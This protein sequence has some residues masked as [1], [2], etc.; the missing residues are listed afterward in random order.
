MHYVGTIWTTSSVNE[1]GLCLGMTGLTGTSIREDGIPTL[2]LIHAVAE[3]CRTVVEAEEMCAGFELRSRGFSLLIGDATGDIGIIEKHVA[4]QAVRRPDAPGDAVWQTNHCCAASL[5]G[6][7]DPGSTLMENSRARERFMAQA[8]PTVDRSFEGL[9]RLYR[10]HG[11][12]AGVCQ[13]GEGGLHTDSAII[14]S[15]DERA[16]WATEGYGCMNPFLRHE[17]V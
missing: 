8:D 10:S 3:G 1:A 11:S 15:P 16:M 2:F 13:H 17:V 5:A 12:P 9:Q 6:A 14:M 4:G 7:D